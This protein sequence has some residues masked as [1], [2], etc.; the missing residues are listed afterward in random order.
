VSNNAVLNE[1]LRQYIAAE[2]AVLVGGQSYKI[3]NRT[4]TRADI[5][6]IRS[7]ISKLLAL[8]AT[9]ED[10]VNMSRGKAKRVLFR[11]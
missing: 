1:R 5:R 10:N 11:E 6:D 9:T 4:L 7:E 3:G 2:K 8:G